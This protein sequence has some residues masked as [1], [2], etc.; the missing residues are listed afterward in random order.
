MLFLGFPYYVAGACATGLM[1]TTSRSA[2]W[3]PAMLILPLM[4]MVYQSYR[5][6]VGNAVA[7]SLAA[8]SL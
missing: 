1:V 8:A 6:H 7:R 4:A 2:G 5:L 3:L